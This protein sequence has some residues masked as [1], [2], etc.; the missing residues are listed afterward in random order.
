MAKIVN[1]F[2]MFT[3]FSAGNPSAHGQGTDCVVMYTQNARWDDIDC[4]QRNGYICEKTGNVPTTTVPRPTT[5]KVPG[6]VYSIYA[7]RYFCALIAFQPLN[8]PS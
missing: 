7:A 5:P 8:A 6:T 1:D 2:K 3:L 4:N